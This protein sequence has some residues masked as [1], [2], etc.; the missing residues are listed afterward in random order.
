MSLFTAIQSI[1]GNSALNSLMVFSA[2]Y[3]VL[4]VPVSLI[5]LWISKRDE[6]GRSDSLFSFFNVLLG[7]VISYIIGIFYFHGTPYMQGFD[8]ILT[9]AAENSF[10]SQHTTVVF[11]LVWSLVYKQRK[12]LSWIAGS[13]AVLT[14]FARIYTGLH[15]P[16]DII[17]GIGASVLGF[18]ISLCLEGYMKRI[19]EFIEALEERILSRLQ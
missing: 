2:K 3:L 19:S 10:P 17:G 7:L 12:K 14:G 4:V 15:F 1:T 11:S 6:N 16:I 8:T 18:L 13:A 9:D 5:Y